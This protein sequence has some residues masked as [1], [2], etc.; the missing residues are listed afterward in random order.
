[1][2]LGETHVRATIERLSSAEA[3]PPDGPGLTGNLLTFFK[4]VLKLWDAGHTA[5]AVGLLKWALQLARSQFRECS[6]EGGPAR[7]TPFRLPDDFIN[8]HER[9]KLKQLM[10]D[11]L[12]DAQNNSRQGDAQKEDKRQW[13]RQLACIVCYLNN[14]TGIGPPVP[15]I[16]VD[17]AVFQQAWRAHDLKQDVDWLT[18]LARV[19]CDGDDPANKSLITTIRKLTLAGQDIPEVS[20][21]LRAPPTGLGPIGTP[22]EYPLAWAGYVPAYAADVKLLTEFIDRQKKPW[23]NKN[24][25]IAEAREWLDEQLGHL[26]PA[27]QVTLKRLNRT[28][29]LVLRHFKQLFPGNSSTEYTPGSGRS[30]AFE[31][32][33]QSAA[34]YDRRKV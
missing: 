32:F 24:N 29:A 6:I 22:E 14:T 13:V 8:P 31:L 30:V 12:A 26:S 27:G 33:K 11:I 16:G 17:A 3:A 1:M 28:G 10:V 21:V 34:K 7:P 9:T 2:S 20:A 19:M 25:N 4:S 18:R 5:T 23:L 15:D